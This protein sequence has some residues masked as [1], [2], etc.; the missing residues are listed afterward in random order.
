M[1]QFENVGLQR[2]TQTVTGTLQML[3]H[4]LKFSPADG[5]DQ[6][7]ILVCY[8][9]INSIDRR[10]TN[11]QG[12]CPVHVSCR[13]FVFFKFLFQKEQEAQDVFS[14]LQKL[15]N[16]SLVEQ[17]YAFQYR[18]DHP[19]EASEPSTW[20]A[21]DPVVE[22]GRMGVGSKAANWRLTHINKDFEFCPTYPRILGVPTRISDNVLK[23][24][25]KFRSKSRIPALSYIHRTNHVSITRSAQPL[26]G[27]K[28]NRSIQDEKLVESIFTTGSVAPV[29]HNLNLIIDARPQANAIAQTALGAGTENVDNYRGCRLVFSGIENIHVMRDSVGKIMEAVQAA[30]GGPVS[31]SLLEKSGWLKHLKALIDGTLL[32]VQNVHLLNNPVLVHCSDGW[33]RTAQLCS[34]SEMCL[35]PYYRTLDGFLVLIDKEWVS[36]GH[37]FRDRLGL[38]SKV[39]GEVV[40]TT[41]SINSQIQVA[42]KNMGFSITSFSKNLLQKTSTGS[43]TPYT[44]GSG[45]LTSSEY[46]N[47]PASPYSSSTSTVGPQGSMEVVGANTSHPKEVSPVFTQFLDATYQ[48]WRQFPT[49][50]EFTE[51]LLLHLNAESRSG[52]FGNFLF[53][54]EKDRVAFSYRPAGVGEAV[55]LEGATCSIW[56]HVR[57]LRAEFSNPLY[58]DPATRAEQ[59]GGVQQEQQKSVVGGGT[60][61][62]GVTGGNPGTVSPD[63]EILYPSGTNL[64]YWNGLF[65]KELEGAEEGAGDAAVGLGV[66]RASSTGGAR[67]GSLQSGRTSR[68]SIATRTSTGSLNSVGSNGPVA[69][70]PVLSSQ[71]VLQAHAASQQPTSMNGGAPPLPDSAGRVKIFPPTSGTPPVATTPPVVARPPSQTTTP[72]PVRRLSTVVVDEEEEVGLVAPGIGAD[73]GG[74]IEPI[75]VATAPITRRSEV[76]APT[77]PFHPADSIQARLARTVEGGGMSKAAEVEQVKVTSSTPLV[78]SSLMTEELDDALA[79]GMEEIGLED[80]D[81]LR[82]VKGGLIHHSGNVRG[83]A[84]VNGHVVSQ[85]SSEVANGAPAN[86]AI[87]AGG[88]ILEAPAVMPHPLWIPGA[89]P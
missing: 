57:R 52:R 22:F 17:H 18:K 75:V 71:V 87:V 40:N 47:R 16:I 62:V 42:S 82:K 76:S 9:S 19:E 80:V 41:P 83:T 36:F 85:Q 2:G 88:A 69:E 61:V 53:N 70:Q 48:L 72:P 4:Q 86:D 12:L 27:L 78:T 31:K 63:G 28:Q 13:H 5:D 30:D 77:P 89:A 65:L 23:H 34:L 54:S 29:A 26:V 55:G 68:A 49:H 25:G 1:T 20:N 24:A 35:D 56:E 66:G 39:S 14:S 7:V 6:D 3:Q 59:A 79:D 60:G 51:K 32:I 50:F 21:F 11:H 45:S 8:A 73:G 44:Y 37:K 43:T 38:L 64:R 33:D 74:A 10:F 81:P 58:I 67:Y 15:I 46:S 84:E